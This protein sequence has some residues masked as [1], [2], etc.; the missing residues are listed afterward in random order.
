MILEKINIP[1]EKQRIIFGA[2]QLVDDNKV[3]DYGTFFVIGS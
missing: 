3:T 1:L 2:K